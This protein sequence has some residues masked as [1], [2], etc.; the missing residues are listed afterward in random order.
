MIDTMITFLG[1]LLLT[2]HGT[3]T[4]PP[5]V[6]GSDDQSRYWAWRSIRTPQLPE[7]SDSDW[8][9]NEIDRFILAR[10][11]SAGLEPAEEAGRLS[12]LRRA[13]FDLTGLPPTLAQQEHYLADRSPDAYEQAIDRLLESP[14]YGER[15]GRHWL[16]VVRYAETNGFERDGKKPEVWRYRDWVIES[17]N[18][19][20]PYD[21]FILEQLAG[22]ELEDR[23]ASSVAATGMHRLGLWDDE[24]TDVPQ[25]I[26]DDLD[27][28]VDTTIRATL[29]MSIGCARCHDHKGDPISQADYYRLTAFFSGIAPYRNTT[30]GTHIA[31][32]H[33]LRAMPRDADSPPQAVLIQRH[34]NERRTLV[35]RIREQEQRST[36]SVSPVRDGLVAHYTL[37]QVSDTTTFD[38]VGTRHARV[39]GT[40][41]STE[42]VAAGALEFDQA[43]QHVVIDRCVDDDFTISFFFR[44]DAVASGS[45]HDPRWF[46]GSGLVDGEISGVVSDFGISMIGD[47]VVA[48]GLGDPERFVASP[49]GFNDGAWHHVAMVRE[50][51]TG[52]FALHLDGILADEAMGSRE[53]LDAQAQLH[54][55]RSRD[56]QRQF[57]GS[58]DEVGFFDR[59][60][61]Q[62]EIFSL[63]SDL[64]PA[65]EQTA[66]GIAGGESTYLND[67]ER[68]RNLS[69]PRTE[70][71]RLLALTESGIHPPETRILGRGSVH[72]PGELVEPGVPE[73]VRQ[74][75]EVPQVT[76]SVHGDSS[77]RRTALANWINDPGNALALRTAVNRIWHHHFGVGIVPLHE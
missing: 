76:P 48:A 13:T 27:S 20:M 1:I 40:P 53:T 68:L 61:G 19:D 59:A 3:G 2:L 58:I 63:A 38:S 56:G 16:D 49:P 64:S 7:V 52:R 44:T 51:S 45:E 71:V 9:R 24:P 15:W 47:G 57:E 35:E 32:D 39:L 11:E 72:A 23:T 6:V 46:L 10:L 74:L 67:R 66:T 55:G 42:G 4:P 22:D 37:D 17:L 8:C 75:A 33:I 29:G 12:L 50:R 41:A 65:P 54:I 69:I 31:Q 25:A 5:E 77:G 34:Q 18:A 26:A 28:I 70:T 21:R 36:A 73:V 60:L 30:G 43:D 14:H 62:D